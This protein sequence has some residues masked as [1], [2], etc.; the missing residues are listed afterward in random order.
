MIQNRLKF[1]IKDLNL[2]HTEFAEKVG[3]Q[4]SSISHILSGRNKPSLDFIEKIHAAFPQLNINWLIF[5]EGVPFSNM[6]QIENK[7]FSP[8]L[9]SEK[10]TINSSGNSETYS[11]LNDHEDPP[12]YGKTPQM[13]T[14][15]AH[16][17]ENK[18]QKIV[19]FYSNGKF[20]EFSPNN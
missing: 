17:L 9:P 19:L 3:V 7:N 18:I 10:N 12:V 11:L 14:P 6:T 5:G 8:T 20:E 2:T 16:G 1:L 4:S 13:N 15:N